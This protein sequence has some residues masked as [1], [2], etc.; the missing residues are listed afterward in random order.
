MCSYSAIYLQKKGLEAV[1]EFEHLRQY[2]IYPELPKEM[3][4]GKYQH[5]Y[6]KEEE[7]FKREFIKKY[8]AKLK[9]K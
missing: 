2:M 8:F 3:T 9:K 1:T 6:E 7:K 5:D 4:L